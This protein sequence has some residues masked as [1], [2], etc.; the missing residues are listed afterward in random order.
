V[1]FCA[2]SLPRPPL[3]PQDAHDGLGVVVVLGEDE[4][5]GQ[6]LP[7]REEVALPALVQG[8]GDGADLVGRLHA[9]VQL[10]G[11]VLEV[12]VELPVAPG[13]GGL[14]QHLQPVAGFHGATGLGDLGLDAVDVVVDVH[15]V[16]HRLRVAVLH[17]QVLVEEAE[18]LLVGRGGQ[19][20][21]V[22][23]EVLQH[24]APQVVDGA[25]RFVGDDD[26][27]GLDRE[28][29]VVVDGG[30]VEGKGALTPAL[31]H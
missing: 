26:V 31:S 12:V 15:A 3:L 16:G 19:A 7:L 30:N 18:G 11:R 22:G 29:G 24:L 4:R 17:H 6:L 1:I 23:V 14:V 2:N 21:Q 27:E 8:A 9:A 5:L 10:F 20:D 13:A 28:G 25:V